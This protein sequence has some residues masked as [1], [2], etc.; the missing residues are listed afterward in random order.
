MKNVP[1]RTAAEAVSVIQ[2]GQRVFVQGSA[3]TPLALLR[4]LFQ[5]AEELRDVELVTISTLGGERWDPATLTGHF[6]VNS[7]F[8]SPNVRDM[9]NGSGGEYVPVFLSEIP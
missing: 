8:V 3:A 4:A 9:V 6:F 1:F 5:R 2:S 7:L